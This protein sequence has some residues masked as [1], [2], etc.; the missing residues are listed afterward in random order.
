MGPPG[1]QADADQAGAAER[2]DRVVVR[3]AGPAVGQHREP[4]VAGRVPPDRRVHRAAQRVR[5]ALH[6]GVVALVHLALAEGALERAV[7]PLAL[8]HDHQPGRV[9][10]QPV[11]DAL[12]LGGA[13]GGDG[14]T[15]GEQ[16]AEDG[17]PGPARRGVGGHP[18]RLVHDHDVVVG[19]D[20]LETG[21]ARGRGRAGRP[22][23]G[24]AGSVTSSQEP[25]STRCDF[26]AGWPPTSTRPSATRSAAFA[27]DSPNIRAS[28]A[29]S[30]SPSRPSGTGT[31]R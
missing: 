21:D 3:D 24:G 23:A 17:R 29:S 4:A 14:V 22:P 15:G 6:Q 10:V 2:L 19:V 13:A 5:V 12:A 9:R 20:H 16:P 31:R 28:A 8:G 7:G 25:A 30:R 26:A 27:R 11:H 1:L 18:G